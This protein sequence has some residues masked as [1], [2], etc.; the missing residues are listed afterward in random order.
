MGHT[1]FA[2]GLR[3]GGVLKMA[4]SML[5]EELSCW[6]CFRLKSAEVLCHPPMGFEPLSRTSVAL[7]V[8]YLNVHKR[9]L[10]TIIIK[11]SLPILQ[12][13]SADTMSLFMEDFFKHNPNYFKHLRTNDAIV[14]FCLKKFYH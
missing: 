6:D 1:F 14:G 13:D 3:C 7:T 11:L 9:N 4:G 5:G 12:H 10:G 8:Q 2:S